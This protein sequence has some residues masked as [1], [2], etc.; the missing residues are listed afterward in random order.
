ML[1]V[2]GCRHRYI[3]I[4]ESDAA[5][6]NLAAVLERSPRPLPLDSPASPVRKRQRLVAAG[7]PRVQQRLDT[8][9]GKAVRVGGDEQASTSAA[10][11]S[12]A[13][14]GPQADIGGLSRVYTQGHHGIYGPP[15]EVKARQDTVDAVL[16]RRA[17]DT[18]A[19]SFG[20]ER[21]PVQAVTDRSQPWG[22]S[23]VS[24]AVRKAAEG[25]PRLPDDLHHLLSMLQRECPDTAVCKLLL[26]I[27][28][29]ARELLSI[30]GVILE[31]VGGHSAC[32]S[33]L[34]RPF[35]SLHIRARCTREPSTSE[36]C[37]GRVPIHAVVHSL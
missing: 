37:C 15:D 35:G 6:A 10:A 13:A 3:L 16:A 32:C 27:L 21:D 29:A 24:A 14:A 36:H 7:R 33:A 25:D 26:C 2:H 12:L 23:P 31:R 34:M 8:V 4:M 5:P 1:P 20:D 17:I 28:V 30:I 9:F 11:R 22:G 19:P 18:G